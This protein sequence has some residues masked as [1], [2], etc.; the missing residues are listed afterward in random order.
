MGIFASLGLQWRIFNEWVGLVELNLRRTLFEPL[1]FRMAKRTC[2]HFLVG[3]IYHLISSL[4]DAW[5]HSVE[6]HIPLWAWNKQTASLEQTNSSLP[7]ETSILSPETCGIIAHWE[8][9]NVAPAGICWTAFP[10]WGHLAWCLKN[11]SRHSEAARCLSQ[12]NKPVWIM[13]CFE[14]C[15]MVM[16]SWYGALD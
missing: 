13:R 3:K 15:L 12:Q 14:S 8:G 16:P 11:H 4:S 9:W 6:I 7:W 10:R 2:D 1:A 5:H